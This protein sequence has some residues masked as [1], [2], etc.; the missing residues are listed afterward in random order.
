MEPLIVLNISISVITRYQRQ[1]SLG[2]SAYWNLPETTYQVSHTR[3]VPGLRKQAPSHQPEVELTSHRTLC[4]L[5]EPITIGSTLSFHGL[6]F[7]FP[8]ALAAVALGT[9]SASCLE[10]ALCQR[11]RP[12]S[13][14]QAE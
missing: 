5:D 4:S 12:G 3:E 7:V 13:H 6:Y 2:Q 10:T 9:S 8:P 1:V 11:A 14:V